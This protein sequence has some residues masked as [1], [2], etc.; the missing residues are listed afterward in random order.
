MD[1]ESLEGRIKMLRGATSVSVVDV[2][3]EIKEGV[4]V[5]KV[6]IKEILTLTLTLTLIGRP[7]SRRF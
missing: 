3:N 6:K 2:V 4:L 1:R 5:V 7:R